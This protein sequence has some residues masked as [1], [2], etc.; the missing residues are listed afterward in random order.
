MT[1]PYP[2]EIAIPPL[3]G[4]AGVFNA[5]QEYQLFALL[6]NENQEIQ[7]PDQSPLV[8]GV[9]WTAPYLPQTP[10]GPCHDGLPPLR[11][12]CERLWRIS[13]AA[14]SVYR[15]SANEPLSPLSVSEFD[16]FETP[17]ATLP[18]FSQTFG[19]GMGGNG[20]FR[21]LVRAND[22]TSNRRFFMDLDESVEIYAYDITALIVG[23]P[24]TVSIVPNLNDAQVESPAQFQGQVVDVRVG[25]SIMPIESPT[26][27]RETRF[28]QLVTVAAETQGTI[29]VPRF[30]RAVKIYQSTASASSGPWLRQAGVINVGTINFT[31]RR[32]DDEDAELGRENAL[33]TD[34]D[35]LLDRVFVVQWT[36]VP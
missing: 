10:D 1:Q 14:Q 4:R 20:W 29:A 22:N 28:T 23:P 26:G 33:L 3:L 24:N 9:G 13:T 34:I 25:A 19:Q 27:L 17:G 7:T 36:I 21:L 2:R 35:A 5:A 31:N 30:A 18:P 16:A 8:S 6:E 32:S 12:K 15:F 11:H